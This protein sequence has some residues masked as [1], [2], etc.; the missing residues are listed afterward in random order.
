MYWCKLAWFHGMKQPKDPETDGEWKHST[1][2]L[3]TVRKG[4]AGNIKYFGLKFY[5][6]AANLNGLENKNIPSK[7]H[8]FINKVTNESS[9]H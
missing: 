4:R 1:K 8:D 7:K 5:N 3:A 9:D 2:T 6:C